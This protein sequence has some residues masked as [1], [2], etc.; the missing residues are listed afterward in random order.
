[1]C[2]ASAA[3]WATGKLIC[4]YNFS[5]DFIHAHVERGGA[6]RELMYGTHY[7]NLYDVEMYPLRFC[8]A[9]PGVMLPGASLPKTDFPVAEQL[10]LMQC[11]FLHQGEFCHLSA[12]TGPV[13]FARSGPFF[14]LGRSKRQT[15]LRTFQPSAPQTF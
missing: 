6:Y 7:D 4:L 13:S 12:F 9:A 3:A 11:V 8:L 5:S 10:P 2:W 14:V 1:M 15:L